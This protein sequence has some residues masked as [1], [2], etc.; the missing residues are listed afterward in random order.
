MLGP[1]AAGQGGVLR[2]SVHLDR[3]PALRADGGARPVH[4]RPAPAAAAACSPTRGLPH[5][6]CCHPYDLCTILIAEE[7]GARAHGRR[8][9]RRST[10][11]STSRRDVAWV[12]YANDALRARSSP[13]CIGALRASRTAAADDPLTAVRV[14][15]LDELRRAGDAERFAPA[16]ESLRA[17][18]ELAR[19][20]LDRT[21][22]VVAR[23]PGRLDVMGGIADY[24]GSLV[25]AAAARSARRPP[26]LQPTRASL[27]RDRVA[28]RRR[29]VRAFSH[30]ARRA[31]AG[32]A[33]RRPT[34]SP[35]GSRARPASGG[36]RTSIGVVHACLVRRDVDDVARR[37]GFRLLIESDVPE[38]K[39]VSS[40][41]ALEVACLAAIAA[42]YGVELTA[43]R[44]RRRASGRRT[45]SP[46][47]RA[48]SWTR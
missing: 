44:S 45:T 25:L 5:P 27:D 24:S 2:G 43:R 3:R 19:G 13:R 9:A 10:R 22:R 8:P 18:R 20:V 28:A 42:R 26:S 12:G 32:R 30:A 21:R 37:G 39:G 29:D 40:S 36:R 31:R 7:L 35:R 4:R 15:T 17:R 23:A 33:A 48:G 1:P 41:A 34:R 14:R 16:R 47:R 38:G 6:L 46:A 11:R